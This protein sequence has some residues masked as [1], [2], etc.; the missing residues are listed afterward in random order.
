VYDFAGSPVHDAV[1]VAH[2]IRPGLLETAWRNVEIELESE[3]CRGMTVVDLLR[4]T[5]REPNAHVAVGIDPDGFVDL[6]LERLS[7]FSS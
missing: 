5:D 7:R 3:L 4:R 6:L 1:A 2:V